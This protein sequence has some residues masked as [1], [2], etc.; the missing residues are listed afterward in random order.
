MGSPSPTHIPNLKDCPHNLTK[1]E[2][3]QNSKN[4]IFQ[5]FSEKIPFKLKFKNLK[6]LMNCK[7]LRRPTRTTLTNPSF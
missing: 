3:K 7:K 5:L 6:F 4:P 2:S 1:Y